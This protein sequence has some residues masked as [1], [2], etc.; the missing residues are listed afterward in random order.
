M[1]HAIGVDV[2]GSFV[3]IVAVE[4]EGRVVHRARMATDTSMPPGSADGIAR[5]LA[6]IHAASGAGAQTSCC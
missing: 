2:G 6:E 3:K 1:R 5:S 4:P